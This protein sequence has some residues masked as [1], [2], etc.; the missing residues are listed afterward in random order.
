MQPRTSGSWFPWIVA[1]I[2]VGVM[3]FRG[4]P[5]FPVP[6]RNPSPVPS[7]TAAF[8][9]E[10][11]VGTRT[12]DSVV[13]ATILRALADTIEHD[14]T[15]KDKENKPA[16]RLKTGVQ[17]DELRLTLRELRMRGW[18]FSARYPSL[19]PAIGEHL[20]AAVGTSG[21]AI[22]DATRAKWIAALKQ[23]AEACDLVEKGN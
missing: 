4:T 5:S 11:D 15:R 3:F 1:A 18:S 23:L 19:G 2:A 17:I 21:G 14:G 10:P 20:S 7:V 12:E 9:H 6:P 16:P 13:M 22:D 8:G